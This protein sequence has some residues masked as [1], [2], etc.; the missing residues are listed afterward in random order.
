MS[1]V[2]LPRIHG[3]FFGIF[4][5]RASVICSL[6]FVQRTFEGKLKTEVLTED[7]WDNLVGLNPSTR[8][9]NFEGILSYTYAHEKCHLRHSPIAM[10]SW[11]EHTITCERK[12]SRH[13]FR[14]H[15]T[16]N[17]TNNT[18]KHANYTIVS[19]ADS[20]NFYPFRAFSRVSWFEPQTTLVI[21]HENGHDF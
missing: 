19:D 12:I 18:T 3:I 20:L 1:H 21:R 8:G 13:L 17:R 16:T 6:F 11:G 4:C 5:T 9:L 14:P 7:S 2:L 10:Y 15:S